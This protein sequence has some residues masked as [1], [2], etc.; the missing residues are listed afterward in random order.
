[1]CITSYDNVFVK[2][3]AICLSIFLS[4]PLVRIHV[5]TPLEASNYQY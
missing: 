4:R 2:I 1:M 3:S 5:D